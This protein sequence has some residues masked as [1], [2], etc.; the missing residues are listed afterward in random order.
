[1]GHYDLGTAI[2]ISI[3]N[4]G[5]FISCCLGLYYNISC[6]IKTYTDKQLGRDVIIFYR[7]SAM[8]W[9]FILLIAMGITSVYLY[10]CFTVFNEVLF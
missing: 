8:V 10:R 4:G 6:Y 3:I 7:V 1:M 2:L 9:C 5:I